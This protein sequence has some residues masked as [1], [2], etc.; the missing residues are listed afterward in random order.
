MTSKYPSY[1]ELRVR[2]APALLARLDALVAS[3][4][5]RSRSD[6]VNASL[7]HYLEGVEDD[8]PYRTELLSQ[9]LLFVLYIVA[10]RY[11]TPKEQARIVEMAEQTAING[12]PLPLKFLQK[13]K[14]AHAPGDTEEAAE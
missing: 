10:S 13:M 9:N 12:A 14:I 7:N 2:V 1:P 11:I 8:A 6:A 5:S 3:G 4:V